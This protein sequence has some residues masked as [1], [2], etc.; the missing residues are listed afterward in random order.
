MGMGQ[1]GMAPHSAAA[2]AAGFEAE[3][4]A[5][6]VRFA[7]D[8]ESPWPRDIRAH[9]EAGFFE[10]PPDNA[11]LGPVRPRGAPN[12][13]ILRRGRPAARWG[14][15]RQVDM[16]FSVAKSY[17]AL[18]AGIAVADG[19]V[20]DL[21][22]PVRDLVDD[23][24]FEGKQNGA[25]TWRQLLQNTSEWEGTLFGK[26]DV[27]D[28]GRNLTVEGQGRKGLPRPLHP[29]G[30]YWEY[31]DVRVNRLS[32]A[33]LRRFGRP[34]PEVFAERIMRPIGASA[35]WEWHG[36]ETSWVEQDGRRLHSVPGG[37]HWGGGVFIHAEDQ[38]LVGRLALQDGVWDGRRLL[39]AGWVAACRTPC[40]LNPHY[41]L[42][43]WLNTGRTRWPSASASSFC[44]SGAG[45]NITWVDPEQDLVAVLRWVDATR[46]DGFMAMVGAA[47]RG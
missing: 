23:G 26:S 9:L 36:Y 28:R 7:L 21:D 27:I 38:A 24:G 32:L 33:L 37:G 20:P 1:D 39:P 43:W 25:V 11:I 3:A 17:L 45:G 30:Q 31:N 46:L 10:P 19:L 14:D 40:A 47:L 6:A 16:T 12:G 4:L 8:H 34:L 18:L 42:L 41:G 13:L 2:T 35:D 44:F 22:A 5:A 15:T 29:P